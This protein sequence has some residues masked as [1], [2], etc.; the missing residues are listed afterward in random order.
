MHKGALLFY[1]RFQKFRQCLHGA[2]AVTDGVFGGFVHFGEGFVKTD[3]AEDR[4][5]AETGG[6]A[7]FGDDFAIHTTF[8]EVLLAVKDEGD[9]GFE[10]GLTV[11]DTLHFG[12]HLPD[13]V[14]EAAACIRCHVL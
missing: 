5:I 8:K 11:G 7:L 12:H 10:A 13:I 3:G 2:A 9:D 4:V 14:L 1:V 6:S